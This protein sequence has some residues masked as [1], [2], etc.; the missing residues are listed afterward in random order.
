MGGLKTTRVLRGREQSARVSPSSS[1][2][3]VSLAGA[4]EAKV[5]PKRG[6]HAKGDRLVDLI[7]EPYVEVDVSG[8]VVQWNRAAE[9][10]VGFTREEAI[11]HKLE[12]LVVLEENKQKHRGDLQ[13]I[14]AGGPGGRVRRFFDIPL[15]C[16]D[17]RIVWVAVSAWVIRRSRE[18]RIALLGHP[19]EQEHELA[20][21]Q[22]E[23]YLHD[24]LTGLPN[25]SLFVFRLA[26]LLESGASN[27]VAVL[28]VDIDRFKHV[29]DSVGYDQGD[30]LLAQFA[31]R[32]E[33][34]TFDYRPAGVTTMVSRLGGDSF[35][36]LCGDPSGDAEAHAVKLANSILEGTARPFALGAEERMVSASIGIAVAVTGNERASDL[37][38]GADAAMERAKDRPSGL[39]YEVF[40]AEVAERVSKRAQVEARLHRALE[41]N[42]LKVFYQPVVDIKSFSPVGAEALLRWD[43]PEEGLVL[44]DRFI[45][46]AEESGLIVP[47][48]AWVLEEASK[49]QALW[50]GQEVLSGDDFRMEVNLSARQIDHPQIVSA[51]ANV[52]DQTGISP[53]NLTLEITESAL[54]RHPETAKEILLALKDLGV[55]LAI[56]DFGTGYSSLTYLRA[57]PLDSLKVDKSFVDEIERDDNAAAIVDAVIRLAHTLGLEVVAEGVETEGQLER[58]ASMGCDFAQG[59]LFSRPVPEEDLL[60][61]IA[62]YLPG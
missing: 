12:E 9:Q 26:Y 2:E 49:R 8:K 31:L 62:A 59:Y 55:M 47:I 34:A 6:K 41:R 10:L 44:P 7:G 60:A 43:H 20:E 56:D 21:R 25:R 37:L 38:S 36:V 13:S 28:L 58:L 29:N 42:E 14:L 16:K 15:C 46:V 39:A 23:A 45:P 1:L 51:V 3:E 54:M 61:W 48:G 27:T 22:A 52:L 35:L 19:L 11:G 24:E 40:G 4:G 30:E 5:L 50:R 57:F 53:S 17:G 18:S 32:I 33:Q